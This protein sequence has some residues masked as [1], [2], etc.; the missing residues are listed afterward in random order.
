MG[1][2]RCIE[3]LLIETHGLGTGV[4]ADRSAPTG[5]YRECGELSGDAK[6]MVLLELVAGAAKTAIFRQGLVCIKFP[7]S[8]SS[9]I[10]SFRW[11]NTLAALGSYVISPNMPK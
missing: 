8:L 1:A 9:T 6:G 2:F 7:R 4:C 5:Y 3:P 11:T 10:L